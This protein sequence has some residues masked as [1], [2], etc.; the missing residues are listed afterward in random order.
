MGIGRITH[1]MSSTLQDILSIASPFDDAFD[2]DVVTCGES[3]Q[4][5]AVWTNCGRRVDLMAR[6]IGWQVLSL[7]QVVDDVEANWSGLD[8]AAWEPAFEGC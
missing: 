2:R 1:A 7:R 3:V 5:F 8:D 4:P 6:T